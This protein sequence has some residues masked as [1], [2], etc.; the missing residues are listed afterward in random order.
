MCL[1]LNTT[2]ST[3]VPGSIKKEMKIMNK[4]INSELP[5]NKTQITRKPNPQEEVQTPE[6]VEITEKGIIL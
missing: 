1:E 3:T 4:S 6:R 5:I 2:Q